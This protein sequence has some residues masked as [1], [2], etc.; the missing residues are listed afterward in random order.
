MALPPLV[1]G[2]VHVSTLFALPGV[3]ENVAVAPG[4]VLGTTATAVEYTPK[5]AALLAAILKKYELPLFKPVR[6]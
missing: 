5:P 1:A 6:T 2:A 4:V 3:T